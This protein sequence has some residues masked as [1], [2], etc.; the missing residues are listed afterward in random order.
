MTSFNLNS[1]L[2][3]LLRLDPGVPAD[4][5]GGHTTLKSLLRLDTGVPAD[6]FGG[7]KHSVY[8]K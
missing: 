1:P 3:P 8:V 2:K 6:D 4:D 7:H 5:F